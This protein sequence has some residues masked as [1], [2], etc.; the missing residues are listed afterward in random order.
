MSI[1]VSGRSSSSRLA[2][3]PDGGVLMSSTAIDKSF[4]AT[5]KGKLIVA[6]VCLAAFL[7]VI[8]TTIV[9]IALPSIREHIHFTVQSLQWIASGYLLTYGGFLLLGGRAADLLGRRRLFVA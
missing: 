7:D 2:K 4:L 6:L 5:G 3:Q 9:N 1:C 8:D